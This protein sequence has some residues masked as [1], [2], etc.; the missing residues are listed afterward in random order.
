MPIACSK[1]SRSLAAESGAAVHMVAAGA[2]Y[3]CARRR[4]T[5]ATAS[6]AAAPTTATAIAR[7]GVTGGKLG[8]ARQGSLWRSGEMGALVA[9]REAR[10]FHQ[11]ASQEIKG[12]LQPGGNVVADEF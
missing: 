9:E 6:T 7:T 11:V 5:E 3:A 4:I 10:G 2:A 8:H 12:Q 1:T